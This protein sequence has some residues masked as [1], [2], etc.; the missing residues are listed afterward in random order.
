MMD[1]RSPQTAGSPQ[2]TPGGSPQ[3]TLERAFEVTLRNGEFPCVVF[4]GSAGK[5]KV[6]RFRE[7]RELFPQVEYTDLRVRSLGRMERP[8]TQEQIAAKEA[9][10]FD[11]RYPI[12][13][14]VKFWSGLKEGEP[15][16]VGKTCHVAT[17]VC[18]TAVAWIDTARSCHAITHVEAIG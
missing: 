4:A 18:G 3:T 16:S 15:T 5:A 9:E 2:T 10:E 7:L 17:V 8:P 6:E 12:G 14:R 1:R 13:T 11:K